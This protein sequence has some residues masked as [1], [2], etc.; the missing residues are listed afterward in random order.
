ML[1]RTAK[2]IGMLTVLALCLHPAAQAAGRT[3]AV[4]LDGR[5]ILTDEEGNGLTGENQYSELYELYGLE[6]GLML[7]AGAGTNPE[8][9]GF[10]L[11]NAQ[12]EALTEFVYQTLEYAGGGVIFRQGD[13]IGLMNTDG[14]VLLQP[15]YTAMVSSG[16]GGYLAHKTDPYDDSPD[17]VIWIDEAGTEHDT[18]VRLTG[19]LYEFSEGL[20]PAF[21]AENGLYGYLGSEGE[22]AIEPRY[23]WAGSFVGGCAP[24][25]RNGGA[26][27]IDS[28]GGWIIEPVYEYL[29]YEKDGLAVCIRGN[30]LSI[31]DPVSRE[32]AA[33]YA[34]SGIYGHSS[35]DGLAVVVLKDR[36]VVV[37]RT[38][39]E[40]LSLANCRSFSRWE[41]MDGKAIVYA[42]EFGQ[43]GACLYRLDGELLAGPYQD[44]MP[45]GRKSGEMYY[46]YIQYDTV[47]TKYPGLDVSLWDEAE[48]TRECGVLSPEGEELCRFRTDYISCLGEDRILFRQENAVIM[49]DFSGN[50][51]KRFEISGAEEEAE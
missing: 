49:A 43:P 30:E 7:Y 15:V 14:K 25:N 27:L 39:A 11:V 3:Y 12:G 34:E 9:A 42:G 18:G 1:K 51:L 5:A 24:A 2:W 44:V 26:G 47:E 50:E 22:W 8:N 20:S 46:M 40:A 4:A 45:L 13:R 29:S 33:V 23:E 6:E 17:P 16:A 19:G 36:T 38:G 41:G 28:E 37:D 32:K 10:A 21:S 48:G 35:P 31:I